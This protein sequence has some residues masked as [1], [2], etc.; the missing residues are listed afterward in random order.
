MASEFETEVGRLMMRFNTPGVAV[1][2]LAKSKRHSAHMGRLAI[3]GKQVMTK[4]ARFSTVC[5][6]KLL[7]TIDLLLL[8]EKGQISLDDRLADHLPELGQG[9]K[10]KGNFLKIR[11]LLSHTG[12]FRS[13][14]IQYLLRLARDSWEKCVEYLHNAPQ[15]FE[16]GTVFEDDHLSHV[17]LGE[18][19]SRLRGKPV[20]DVVCEDVLAP[21]G[22]PYSTRTKDAEQPDIYVAR[23]EW[24]KDQMNWRIEPDVYSEPDASYG[25]ISHLSMTSAGLLQLGEALLARNP[26]SG[27][28]VISPW[29]KERLFSEVVRVPR[30]VSPMRVTR[31][32]IAAFGLGMA[33][34]RGGHRGFMTTGRGQG[35]TII[36]D[37]DRQSVLASAMN[38]TNVLE[39]EVLLNILLSKFAGDASIVPEPR[40]L[41][42]GFDEFIQPFSTRD[43][44][45][46]YVGFTPE[47]VEIVTG[48]RSFVVRIGKEDR[49]QFEASPENR[50][51]IR[52]KMPAPIGLFQDPVS[53]RPCLTIGMHPHKKVS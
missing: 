25:A 47:P 13:C 28:A 39:R 34:F 19:L 3:G 6:V 52:A 32:H 22:I 41:D 37:K 44:G 29:V 12:G 26:A 49:Y 30:E 45:G 50:L 48:P 36:F 14:P 11:H 21:L 20:V 23:H 43:I 53:M 40:S 31:W 16:P 10:A 38:T 17:I 35:S 1:E 15:I 5:L 18:L 27:S 2:L 8:A 4:R 7:I 51:V 46:L 9:P 33:T 24:D 42:I